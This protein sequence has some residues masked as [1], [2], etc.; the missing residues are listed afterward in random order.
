VVLVSGDNRVAVTLISY[1]DIDVRDDAGSTLGLDDY[2]KDLRLCSAS[3]VREY[4]T[5]VQSG[6][7]G[8]EPPSVD[9]I[10]GVELTRSMTIPS[11]A[12]L[13]VVV[14][15]P[16][17]VRVE[18]GHPAWFGSVRV[19][20]SEGYRTITNPTVS[21]AC[22]VSAPL[23][24]RGGDRIRIA[25]VIGRSGR[26]RLSL[27]GSSPGASAKIELRRFSRAGEDSVTKSSRVIATR[28]VEGASPDRRIEFDGITCGYY[29]LNAVEHDEE[30]GLRCSLVSTRVEA[31][32]LVDV[33]ADFNAG[34][35]RVELRSRQPVVGARVVIIAGQVTADPA[36]PADLPSVKELYT[37]TDW[38]G[39]W[40]QISGLHSST[41]EI[42]IDGDSRGSDSIA[43]DTSKKVLYE[44]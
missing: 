30:G 28:F 40:L 36:W 32:R 11:R 23:L 15:N 13:H 1:L 25:V 20:P 33:A 5:R 7:E 14:V 19:S 3:S 22:R 10:P 6:N 4:V 38:S 24:G 34:P 42:I 37:W 43:F 8:G 17:V 9:K 18:P 12:G 2:L 35:V 31:D 41:G 39:Q 27:I 26:V 16:T 21:G 44:F 29:V